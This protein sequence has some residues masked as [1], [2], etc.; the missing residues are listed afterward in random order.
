MTTDRGRQFECC[1]FAALTHIIGARHIHTAAYHPSANGLERFHRQLKASLTARGDREHL[2]DHLP[3]VLLGIISTF[4]DNLN[5]TP[6]ELVYGTTLRLPG[7]FLSAP[8]SPEPPATAYLQELQEF[9]QHLRPSPSR[10]PSNRTI[11]VSRDLDTSSHV[12]VRRDAVKPPLT[13]PY[14]GP[15]P[16]ISRTEKTFRRSPWK[17]RC[18]SQGQT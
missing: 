15:Y 4:K 14:D 3:Y 11:F 18:D 12:F 1:F 9:L 5:G 13:P 7:D 10:T 8:S 16:V 2:S 17:T 6:A